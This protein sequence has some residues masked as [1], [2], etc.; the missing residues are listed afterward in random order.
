MCS[1]QQGS[2]DKVSYFRIPSAPEHNDDVEAAI[3]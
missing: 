1:C 3:N 2:R